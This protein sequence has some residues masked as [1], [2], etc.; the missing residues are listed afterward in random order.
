MGER[1][2]SIVSSVAI[3]NLLLTAIVCWVKSKKRPF[4]F[5]LGWLLFA[6]ALAM[7]SNLHIYLGFGHIVFYHLALLTNVSSGAYLI[8]FV[9]RHKNEPS[10]GWLRNLILFIP[11]I[12][13]IPFIFLCLVEPRWA[14]DTISLAA[15]GKLLVPGIIYN[16]MIILYSI[17][18]NLWLLI[19]NIREK[20]P[21]AQ[22]IY[23]NRRVEILGV[24]LALQLMAFVPFM[25][26]LDIA[27]VILYMPV[28]GQMYYL[29]LFTRLWALDVS[30][31]NI[32]LHV[33]SG[34][35]DQAVKYASIKLSTEKQD[36]IEQQIIGIMASQKPYLVADYA[37]SDLANELGLPVHTVSMVI[38][39]KMNLTFPDLINKY[40]IE[41]A[42]TLLL[43]MKKNHSTIE[44]VAYD[45]GFNN[46]TSFYAAFR[47][48]AGQS[49]SEYLAQNEKRNLSVG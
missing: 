25:I 10:K 44:A 22:K 34:N 17:G 46:R 43:D 45:C 30:Q 14:R 26:K 4:Y 36:A 18:A 19:A 21:E 16:M 40:R 15:E 13:Y 6:S 47:K 23:R 33:L 41:M 24:M 29:Y 39:S 48:F 7:V 11:T 49:P 20:G 31:T 3:I 42:K 1:V 9:Q 2:V 28:F 8:L 38:N 35:T 5:W 27:Y 12:L 37:L 32:S